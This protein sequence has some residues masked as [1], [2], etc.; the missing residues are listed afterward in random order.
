[1]EPG[2]GRVFRYRFAKVWLS[3]WESLGYF[4][5]VYPA[6]TFRV[7][8]FH[9]IPRNLWTAFE[10]LV[11]YVMDCHGVLTPEEAEGILDGTSPPILDTRI[12]CLLTFDDG[13]ESHQNVAKEILNRYGLK[14][15]FFVCPGLMDISRENQR[16]AIARHIF[17]GHV[18]STDLPDE[19]A[20]MFWSDLES[21][22]G[23]GHTIGSHATH[24]LRLSKLSIDVLQREIVESAELLASR[25]GISTRWFAYPFGDLGSIDWES[26]G[27]I[28]TRYE[29]CC[30]GIRGMNSGRTHRLGLLRKHLDLGTP[31]EYQK[32]VLEGG[33]DF[34]YKVQA[35]RLQ[36][37]IN[38]ATVRAGMCKGA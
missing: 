12:P 3:A 21:L 11:R 2:M 18:R 31:F 34:W 29:F 20:L 14:A 23:S 10:S 13:F 32:L 35:R 24:H 1:M 37:M 17:D 8:L 22:I 9:D 6:G 5:R 26:Y 25:L 4:K 7:L 36:A 38:K 19:M 27:I 30:S 16:E 15:I 33:L 28:G